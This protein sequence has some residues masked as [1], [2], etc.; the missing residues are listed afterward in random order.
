MAA[1]IPV[2]SFFFLNVSDMK[3]NNFT[4]D[5]LRYLV[6]D[7]A[8]LGKK[9]TKLLKTQQPQITKLTLI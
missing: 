2:K 8:L 7:G 4:W 1:P 5:W 9:I 6:D 3:C